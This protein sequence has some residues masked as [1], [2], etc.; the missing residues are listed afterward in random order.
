MKKWTFALAA[1]LAVAATL[2]VSAADQTVKYGT[3]VL[4]GEMDTIYNESAYIELENFGFYTNGS[5]DVSADVVS[6]TK[7]WYLWDDDKLYIFAEIVDDTTSAYDK[8]VDYT[9]WSTCDNLEGHIWTST[10]GDERCGLHIDCLGNGITYSGPWEN[11]SIEA[12]GKQTD[13]GYTME[14]AISLID[15]DILLE[16][17]LEFYW[18]LQYNNYIPA[19]SA[20]IASGY[21]AQ[22]Q[23]TTLVLSSEQASV[24]PETEAETE[25]ET[26]ADAAPE[27]V[28]TTAPA[29]F[30]GGLAAILAM[31]TA[32][33]TWF[34]SKKKE[35]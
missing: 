19:D 21:Q 12:I 27:A 29:T 7:A 17:D 23:A 4:D 13:T 10:T 34:A 16:E 32:A 35:H 33:A 11:A 8:S 20:C 15:T 30:D 14:I 25:P 28:T 6:G 2:P 31:G 22:E 26:V 18:G 3:P 1:F 9:G 5:T 24:E